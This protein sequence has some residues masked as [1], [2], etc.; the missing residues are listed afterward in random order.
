MQSKRV[1]ITLKFSANLIEEEGFIEP[2]DWVLF[3]QR[4]IVQNTRTVALTG[5]SSNVDVNILDVV[6]IS[7]GEQSSEFDIVRKAIQGWDVPGFHDKSLDDYV[8]DGLRAC[9]QLPDNLRSQAVM[10]LSGLCSRV[11]SVQLVR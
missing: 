7:N 4:L 10:L 3:L 11:E 6:T 9:M 5:P 1:E 2:N 8:H